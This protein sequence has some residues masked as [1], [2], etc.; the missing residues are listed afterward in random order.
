MGR[1]HVGGRPPL[2]HTFAMPKFGKLMLWRM[3]RGVPSGVV[4]VR[5]LESGVRGAGGRA[6]A[7][8][9]SKEEKKRRRPEGNIIEIRGCGFRMED[10]VG[11]CSM[12]AVLMVATWGRWIM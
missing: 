5:G 8:R 4:I 12:E 10:V 11:F 1:S 7:E 3:E 9:V 2:G 6:A